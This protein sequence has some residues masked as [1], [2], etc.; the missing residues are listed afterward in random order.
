MLKN[1]I[2]IFLYHLRNNKLFSA[3]NIFGL[4][5]G[6]SGLIFALLYWNEE[7]SYDAWNPEKDNV[8]QVLVQLIGMPVFS[9]CALFLKPILDKD[10]NVEKVVYADSWYQKDKIIYKGKKEIVNKIINVEPDFFSLFPFEI[11][12]GDEVSA[13]KDDSSVAI[14]D[15]IVKRVFGD[16]NPIG[17]QITCLDQMFIV[18]AV[19]HIPGNSSIAP[20]VIMNKMTQFK[21][22]NTTGP[23]IFKL[24]LKIKDPSKIENTRKSLEKTYNQ[25][26]VRRI[27]QEEG[28]TLEEM[29][30]KMGHF[31]VV[32]EPLSNARLHSITD[33]YPEGRGNYQFLLIM[34]GLSVLILILSIVNYINLATANAV[35]RAKEVGVRKVVGASKG[36][37]VIQFIFETALISLFSILLALVIVELT[38]PY[39]NDFLNKSLRII[40]SQFYLQLILIF[41]ITVLVAG[42]LPAV[43]VANFETLKV[44]KGNFGRSKNGIWLRNGMLIF[45]FTVATFFIVGSYIVYQQIDYLTNKDLGFKGDQVMEINLNFPDSDYEVENVGQNIY[46]KYSTIKQELAKIKG[47]EQ[48]S[49]GLISFDGSDDSLGGVLYNDELFKARTIAVDFGMFEM[50]KIE[51]VKGRSLDQQHASDTITSVVINETAQKLMNMKE[52]IGKELIIK[53]RKLKII[54][55]VKDF[56]LL[57]PEVEV[58]GMYFYHLKTVDIAQNIN[59]VFVKLKLDNIENTITDIEKLW[60]KMDTEYPFK[61][62]FVDKQYARTYESYVKQKNLF[63]LLNV[64]VIL[65]ALFGLFAL[66]SYSIQRRMKEI[67]IRKTLGA[68]TNLLLKELSKQYVLY[69]VIGFLIALFPTYY[70]LN[71]WLENFAF[72][73]EMTLFPFLFGFIILLVLTLIIVLLRAYQATKTDVLKYLKYE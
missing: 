59:K 57:S 70:L 8:Y 30:K 21:S 62:D 44:L 63:S 56:N 10:T 9:D 16:E 46:N 15:V 27:A 23:F 65:I 61:Y 58:S 4:A 33:G 13:L 20:D 22:E 36:T 7:Q 35:K 71:M 1:W 53:E 48:A 73:I 37:I 17:K 49:T 60:T 52:P 55:V 5:I 69:C 25:D 14:S 11:I 54:G 67:A 28:F 29:A 40:G 51:V 26:F 12:K 43:Y 45:Q 38:L 24:L 31:N 41:C 50:M 39:Y 19:Y 47:V 64:V 66:A 3:L 34:V 6:I 32:I 72:R 68:E 18:R 2:T 42:I